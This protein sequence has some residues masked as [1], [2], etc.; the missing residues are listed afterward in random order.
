[1]K[2]ISDL[3]P[4]ERRLLKQSITMAQVAIET[5]FCVREDSEY[6][7]KYNPCDYQNNREYVEAGDRI[8]NDAFYVLNDFWLKIQQYTAFV[9]REEEKEKTEDDA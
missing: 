9:E 5:I 4:H 7:R 3:T 2:H 1:M 6:I 8:V